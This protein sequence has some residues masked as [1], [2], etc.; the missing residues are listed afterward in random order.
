MGIFSF[1]K[2]SNQPLSS[3]RKVKFAASQS[4]SRVKDPRTAVALDMRAPS[5]FPRGRPVKQYTVGGK[6]RV[7]VGIGKWRTTPRRSRPLLVK[8]GS[9]G[10]EESSGSDSASEKETKKETKKGDRKKSKPYQ[11]SARSRYERRE[12]FEPGDRVM[13]KDHV[14]GR[15]CIWRHGVV[16]SF[17]EFPPKLITPE[18]SLMLF[19]V[20]Y[21]VGEEQQTGYFNPTRYG[22]LYDRLLSASGSD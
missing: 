13:V 7:A 18:S 14:G 4:L 5:P 3:V 6:S 9:L 8:K 11:L 15:R 17:Q 20:T 12:L 19:A 16:A 21:D 1:R 22:I 10:V 2:R